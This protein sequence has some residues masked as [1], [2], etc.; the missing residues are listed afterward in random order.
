LRIPLE[1]LA[2]DFR[3]GRLRAA[4]T[5]EGRVPLDRLV[6]AAGVDTPS[7]LAHAGYTLRLRHAPGILAHSAPLPPLTR[8]VHDGPADLSFKQMADGS[9]VG[10]D[11]PLPPDRP[12]HAGIRTIATDFPNESLRAMHGNR[13][14]A[15]IAAVMPAAKNARLERVTLGFRPMP[16]DDRPV[17][18]PVPGAPDVYVCVTHS[19]ITLAPILARHATREIIDGDRVDDLAPYRLE[20]FQSDKALASG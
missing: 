10:T 2:I 11:A 12:E 19:G 17:I 16:L 1:V 7:I 9:L 8:I 13:I 5:P 3:Q 14:L 20:R 15:R 6:V 18:G 4:V